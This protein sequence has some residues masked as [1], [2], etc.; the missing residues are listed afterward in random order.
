M[1]YFLH[2]FHPARRAFWKIFQGT[3]CSIGDVSA[4][5]KPQQYPRDVAR[6]DLIRIG[7]DMHKAMGIVVKDIE[8]QHG[9]TARTLET[10]SVDSC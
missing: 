10:Q 5:E 6:C 2:D 1:I 8:T 9:R 3:L 7:A 4:W